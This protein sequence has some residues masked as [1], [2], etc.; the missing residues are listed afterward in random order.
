MEA[1]EST[2]LYVLEAVMLPYKAERLEFD[3][4]FDLNEAWCRYR[5]LPNLMLVDYIKDGRL[6]LRWKPEYVK[7]RAGLDAMRDRT[8]IEDV[9]AGDSDI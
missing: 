4:I 1:T 9:G 8:Q 6:V 5:D 3:N 7:S 2:Q